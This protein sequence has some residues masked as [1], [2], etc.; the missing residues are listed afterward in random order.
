M[1]L[2][3]FH[4]A[5][6]PRTQ[7]LVPPCLAGQ[8]PDA[9][10]VC[11]EPPGGPHRQ[12]PHAA[13]LRRHA[14]VSA[15]ALRRMDDQQAACNGPCAPASRL[16]AAAGHTARVSPARLA[17]PTPPPHLSVSPTSARAP[18]QRQGAGG[19]A[20]HAHAAGAGGAHQ[21]ELRLR[22]GGRRR[23]APAGHLHRRRPAPQPAAGGCCPPPACSCSRPPQPHA[24]SRR[25]AALPW[26]PST[27]PT[28]RSQPLLLYPRH[29]IVPHIRSAPRRG[30]TS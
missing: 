29:P 7:H 22:A 28:P 8:A 10:P 18:Q 12:A 15:R 6:R 27:H 20:Q 1:M 19:G 23:A 13:R 21:Q 5:P 11:H 3:C 4:A 26:T 24:A 16:Q 17:S 25:T 30:E 14:A 9:G 2:L